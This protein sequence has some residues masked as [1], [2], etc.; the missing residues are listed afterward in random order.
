MIRVPIFFIAMTHVSQTLANVLHGSYELTAR[1]RAPPL[2]T[3]APPFKSIPPRSTPV[4]RLDLRP[5]LL[6]LAAHELPSPTT[7]GIVLWLIRVIH[8]PS[9]PVRMAAVFVAVSL[10]RAP[11]VPLLSL[12]AQDHGS[13]LV[14]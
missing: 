4:E 13:S 10:T 3:V 8:S 12:S 14:E 9:P 5:F 7:Q 6:Q 2:R 11:A 1:G